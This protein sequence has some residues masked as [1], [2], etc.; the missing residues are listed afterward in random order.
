MMGGGESAV[1]PMSGGAAGDEPGAPASPP[2]GVP[3]LDPFAF[4]DVAVQNLWCD[5]HSHLHR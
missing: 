5:L 1:E 4:R 2:S 3:P